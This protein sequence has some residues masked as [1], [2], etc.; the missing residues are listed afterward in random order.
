MQNNEEKVHFIALTFIECLNYRMALYK[1][2]ESLT[3]LLKEVFA[4]K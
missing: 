4:K 3:K 1:T 2:N